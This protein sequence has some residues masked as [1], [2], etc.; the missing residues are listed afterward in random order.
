MHLQERKTEE[1][2]CLPAV[3]AS[4]P[5]VVHPSLAAARHLHVAREAQLLLRPPLVALLLLL[6]LVAWHHHLL[7]PS[8]L[9]RHSPEPCCPRLPGPAWQREVGPGSHRHPL[10][11]CR[12]WEP[13]IAP[14]QQR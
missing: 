2:S 13:H 7:L 12:Y 8:L 4:Q 1:A 3:T 9:C 11:H 5:S 10:A 14:L 6:L